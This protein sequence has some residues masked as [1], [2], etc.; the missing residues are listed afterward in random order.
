MLQ[1]IRTNYRHTIVACYIGYVIQAISINFAPLL[2]ITFSSEFQLSLG[3]ITLIPTVTF[4]VQLLVDLI[5]AKLVDR[6]GY[7]PCV[8]CAHV[9]AFMG[10]SGLSFLPGLFSDPYIGLMIAVVLYSTGSGI[11]EVVISPMVE[12][13][14]TDGKSGAMS[15]L[16][17]FYCWGQVL[18]VLLSTAFFV[19]C[20]IS[21]WRILALLFSAV[22]F[23]NFFYF[24]AVPVFSPERT[25][26]NSSLKAL[27]SK[28][29]F[30]LFLLLMICGGASE[31]AISQWAS[32]LAESAL[33]Q[34][35]TLGDLAGPCAFAV[36]MG[37]TR[38]LYGAFSRRIPLRKMMLLSACLCAGC[39][40]VVAFTSLP[41]LALIACGLCGFTV[42]LFWPGTFSMA[43]SAIP[44]AGTALF[45][46]MALAG[47]LG[48]A[49]GPSLIGWMASF[50][51][52]DLKTGVA[53]GLLFP[54]LLILGLLLLGKGTKRKN[55]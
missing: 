7:R 12:S 31:V 13:C 51:G 8:L 19:T 35:K 37:T 39:Y 4:G 32:S 41:I 5:S 10:L 47:D 34:S 44:G 20:G 25:E 2:F 28:G 11:I 43:T 6:I 1:N 14:P 36:C 24:L 38:T 45:A 22:P 18:T 30:W 9:L 27:F 23:L 40:L 50:S 33:G 15:L 3:Q 48:C 26:E 21:H 55:S 49:A 46:L 17:S 16:H 54:V 52:G 42:G 29:L 53:Y